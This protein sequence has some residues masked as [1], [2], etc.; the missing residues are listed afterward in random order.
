MGDFNNPNEEFNQKNA[1]N[2]GD[3]QNQQPP[4]QQPP[5]QQP[6]GQPPYQQGQPPYQQPQ[7][8]SQ[9]QQQEQPPYQQGQPSY[10][11]QS[12]YQQ[13]QYGGQ[14]Q[15]QQPYNNFNQQPKKVNGMAIGAL[16]CGIVSVMVN[17][18][19]VLGILSIIIAIGGIVLGII[20]L[21]KTQDD[22]TAKIMAIV[23][24]V[25]SGIGALVA[26]F[27]MVGFLALAGSNG[28]WQSF[29]EGFNSGYYGY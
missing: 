8:Q 7:G 12:Q 13:P 22:K 29:S 1:Q 27:S 11:G 24:L 17:C 23:G 14:S 16:V 19:M 9:Y 5:Y 10:N 28:F 3:A 18:C 25:L 21:K 2:N 26:I 15:Y 4:Y 20:A 6:Q